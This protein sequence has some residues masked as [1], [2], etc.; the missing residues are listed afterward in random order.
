[1]FGLYLE[2]GEF[3]KALSQ[4]GEAAGKS[5]ECMGLLAG[6]AYAFR[7]NAYAVADE[8]ITA[9]NDSTAVSVKFG[10]ESFGEL[11]KRI[12]EAKRKGKIIVGWIHSHPNY[13]CF[14]SATDVRTQKTYFTEEFST[15][16][17]TDPVR[18]ETKAFKLVS[19]NA[20]G[21]REAGFATYR[22]A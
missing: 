10:H 13:G 2:Q 3:E 21:Y 19:G 14:L 9:G 6:R 7:G 11:A 15:A 16:V 17:V 5:R 18:R 4:A 22:K 8:Y 12:N 20:D 1:M